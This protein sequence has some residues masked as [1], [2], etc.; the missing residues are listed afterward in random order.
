[1]N[2]F[3]FLIV[4]VLLILNYL[5]WPIKCLIHRI[6]RRIRSYDRKC[7]DEALY[8]ACYSGCEVEDVTRARHTLGP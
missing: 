2:V 8:I 6:F 1:M 4:G 7:I 5:K 3:S